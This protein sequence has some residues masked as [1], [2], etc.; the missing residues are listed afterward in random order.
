MK[1]GN[2]N[3]ANKKTYSWLYWLCAFVI[4]GLVIWISLDMPWI[5]HGPRG[6]EKTETETEQIAV[7]DLE[8][9][10]KVGDSAQQSPIEQDLPEI[11]QDETFPQIIEQ[12]EQSISHQDSL[13]LN[14]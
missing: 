14:K 13:I 1:N 11:T 10:M 8:N 6:D 9:Q 12:E 5:N 4:I 7:R 2:N 3:A